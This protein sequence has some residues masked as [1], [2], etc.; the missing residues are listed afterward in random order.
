MEFSD[1]LVHPALV[2]GSSAVLGAPHRLTNERCALRTYQDLP[3]T[4]AP[5]LVTSAP[6]LVTKGTTM[7][8]YY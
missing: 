4:K 6:L 8:Y 2:Q 3:V 1:R 7:H 5:L